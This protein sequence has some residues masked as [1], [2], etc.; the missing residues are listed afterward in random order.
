MLRLV[1]YAHTA[2]LRRPFTSNAAATL[3]LLVLAIFLPA[4][5]SGAATPSFPGAEGFG[6]LA[7][8]GRGGQNYC[9]T[10]LDDSGPGTFRDAA[11][12]SHRTITFGVDGA[13]HLKSNLAVSSDVTIL[14]QTAPGDGITLYGH[15]I[16][17]SGSSNIVVRYLRIREGIGGDRG[18]CSVNIVNGSDMILIISP[19]N[20]AAGIAWA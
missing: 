11:S 18:K 16:S 4:L 6:A 10:N 2:A 17:F 7:S 12:E 20:G 14:G 19:S 15:S 1:C 8:G 5:C 13:V 9:V 3:P